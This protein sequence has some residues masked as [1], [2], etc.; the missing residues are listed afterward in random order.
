MTESLDEIVFRWLSLSADLQPKDFKRLVE[1]LVHF[2][3][4]IRVKTSFHKYA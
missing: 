3:V 4:A 1:M 2:K